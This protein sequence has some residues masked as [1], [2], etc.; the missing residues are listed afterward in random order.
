MQ[1][2]NQYSRRQF[3]SLSKN[4]FGGLALFSLLAATGCNAKELTKGMGFTDFGKKIPMYP[5]K[6]KSV[7][8]L[9]MDGGISQ[10]DSF[11]PKPRLAKQ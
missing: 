10:V 8:F 6:A 1:N 5:A 2:K 4:G 3:L 11:D 9:Y 7:I